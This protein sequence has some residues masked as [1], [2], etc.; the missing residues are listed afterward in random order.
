MCSPATR[1]IWIDFLLRMHDR[2]Q[3]GELTGS[4]RAMCQLGRCSDQELTEFLLEIDHTKTGVVTDRN[5]IIT[6]INR[7]MREKYEERQSAAKRAKDYRKRHNQGPDGFHGETA[8]QESNA[9]RHGESNAEVTPYSSSSSSSSSSEE[10][11]KSAREPSDFRLPARSQEAV[12]LA[13]QA[14]HS[15]G[16]TQA[17]HDRAR[18]VATLYPATASKDGRPISFPLAAQ[19]MLANRIAQHPEYP[20][21]E[22]ASLAANS[23]TPVDGLKWVEDMPNLIALAKLRQAARPAPERRKL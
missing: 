3:C 14:K 8:E 20:W 22:H 4:R 6:V 12:A 2:D 19:N 23:P 21:E 1:G 16:A 9:Q 10:K 11:E 13:S 15:Q 5:G 18:Q 7:R 17:D